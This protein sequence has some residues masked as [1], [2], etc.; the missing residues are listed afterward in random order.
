MKTLF[1]I[2]LL[3]IS[4]VMMSQKSEEQLIRVAYMSAFDQTNR[5]YFVY[6]PQGYQD[7]P[8]KK[9]PVI[10]FLHGDGERGNGKDELDYTLIHGPLYEAWVQKRDLPFIMIVPQLHMFGRD[11]LGLSYITDRTRDWIPKRLEEG[12]PDKPTK[13]K[14][15]KE[16]TGSPAIIISNENSGK[17]DKYGW[18]MVQE[19][20]N[21][22]IDQTALNFNINPSKIYLT[23]LSYGGS[24]TFYTAGK[25]PER[26]AAIAPIVGVGS[27]DLIDPIAEE[28]IPTWLF[29]GG[30]DY[31]VGYYYP[32]I[33]KLEKLSDADI[34][35]TIH[36][37]MGHDAWKRIFAG[38]DI[39][40]WFLEHSK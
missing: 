9:W 25:N 8:D 1:T 33:N 14:S 34:R 24:G 20:L 15:T 4:F 22:M 12:T 31:G 11:S 40:D 3:L 21:S 16:M 26:Y 38:Q 7:E 13:S 29:A 5:E 27:L 36:A 28:K 39:Y 37:D 10:L 18:N 6:L 23:G 19:D 2:L 32:I 35:F 30:R 17:A